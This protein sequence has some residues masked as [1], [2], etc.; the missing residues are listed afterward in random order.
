MRVFITVAVFTCALA[1]Q[2][3]TA[4]LV[5]AATKKPTRNPITTASVKKTALKSGSSKSTP[6]TPAMP[7]SAL[8]IQAE[9][10]YARASAAKR[11]ADAEAAVALYEKQLAEIEQSYYDANDPDHR[12]QEITRRFKAAKGKLETARKELAAAQPPSTTT[13]P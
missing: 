9:Q 1:L 2:A 10:N 12:D 11:V 4:D 7:K 3:D 13:N 8:V 6:A 5:K